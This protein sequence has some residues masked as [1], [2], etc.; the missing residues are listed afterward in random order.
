[1]AVLFCIF[2]MI[3]LFIG[4]IRIFAWMLKA[5]FHLIP[6]LF[7]VV[8]IIAAICF[9]WYL[10]QAIGVIA[11]IVIMAIGCHAVAKRI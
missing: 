3:A 7:E 8:F 2:I 1:M 6:F 11:A 4:I 9:A 10:L 5:A